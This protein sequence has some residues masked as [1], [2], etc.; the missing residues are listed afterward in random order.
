M[1]DK[2]VQTSSAIP[3]SIGGPPR[4]L[5]SSSS[6]PPPP[7]PPPPPPGKTHRPQQTTRGRE[8]PTLQ[9]P[10]PEQ[11]ASLAAS[12]NAN[13]RPRNA[14]PPLKSS[15]KPANNNVEPDKS[16][17]QTPPATGTDSRTTRLLT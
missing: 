4:R 11:K 7:P 1:R 8:P 17:T 9:R 3:A 16:M 6:S 10:V 12:S 14:S 5:G 13:S 15:N 2:E